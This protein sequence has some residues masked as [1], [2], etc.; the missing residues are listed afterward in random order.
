[1]KSQLLTL[2]GYQDYSN[3]S[4]SLLGDMLGEV[5]QATAQLEGWKSRLRSAKNKM[6]K[7]RKKASKLKGKVTGLKRH[8]TNLNNQIKNIQGQVNHWKNKVTSVTNEY[9]N[10]LTETV[11]KYKSQITEVKKALDIAKELLKNKDIQNKLI[12][13]G[14]LAV[15]MPQVGRAAIAMR[16][17]MAQGKNLNTIIDTMQDT[18]FTTPELKQAI[19]IRDEVK[20]MVKEKLPQIKAAA[21]DVSEYIEAIL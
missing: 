2:E 6:K 15:G 3:E 18:G 7:W 1:M 20:N 13:A 17:G 10:K 14:S 8:I 12:M 21:F 16:E 9:K 11:N 5:H 4:S 19:A